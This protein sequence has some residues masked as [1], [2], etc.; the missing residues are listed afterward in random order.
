MEKVLESVLLKLNE[1]A[2]FDQYHMTEALLSNTQTVLSLLENSK[3]PLTQDTV[4]AELACL[5]ESSPI[6]ET[7]VYLYSAALSIRQSKAVFQSMLEYCYRQKEAFA[8]STLLYL[9]NQFMSIVFLAPDLNML[10]A[11]KYMQLLFDYVVQC[12]EKALKEYLIPISP[13]ER[14][15]DMVL[16]LT[17]QFLSFEHG[18]SKSAADRCQILMKRMGKRVLLINTA[19]LL[20]PVGRIPFV[21]EHLANY[22]PKYSNNSFIEWKNSEIPFLQCGNNMPNL[23]SLRILLD[24]IRELRPAYAI[25]IGAG[26]ILAS[27]TAKLIPTLCIGMIPSDLSIIGAKFQTLGRPLSDEDRAFLDITGR[28][29]A[30]IIVGTFGSSIKEQTEHLTREAA[31]LPEEAWL[32]AVV[33]ARLNIELTDDFWNM[34]E[35]AAA[36]GLEFVL[37][38]LF[39]ETQLESIY[40]S[41]PSLCGKVHYLGFRQDILC[42]LDFCDLYINPVRRGGG[43]SCVEAMSLGIP[44]ITTSYGDV[45]VNTGEDFFTDSYETMPDL[46]HHYMTDFDFYALQS[47]KAQKRASILLNA[48][49]CF[50]QIINEFL[51][52]NNQ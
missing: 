50:I 49:N 34:A 36:Y 1:E 33:G 20:S 9:C 16:V 29:E 21:N 31:S 3:D 22:D 32:A 17:E 37:L 13:Y 27:M 48:E 46:I 12:Y 25:S 26:K 45:A 38:G 42:F 30:D 23:E 15:S 51:E 35:Q 14:D 5:A 41:R 11:K 18:P 44:V 52:R 19:E 7:G 24:T 39:D 2:L 47:A 43:T 8:P 6:V 10:E 28:K 40:Q 4:E